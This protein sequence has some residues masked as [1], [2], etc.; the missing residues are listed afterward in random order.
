MK[1]EISIDRSTLLERL[2]LIKSLLLSYGGEPFAGYFLVTGWVWYFISMSHTKIGGVLLSAHA[3]DQINDLKKEQEVFYL[4]PYIDQEAISTF[5][6]VLENSDNDSV[7]FAIQGSSDSYFELSLTLDDVTVSERLIS[8]KGRITHTDF[9]RYFE[10]GRK[11]I[12]AKAGLDQK[13]HMDDNPDKNP[14]A[15][16]LLQNATEILKEWRFQHVSIHNK[17]DHLFIC[18]PLPVHSRGEIYYRFFLLIMKSII[19]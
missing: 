16:H 12:S 2:K 11:D 8:K 7:G 17:S 13:Y 19:K 9:N 1:L 18:D 14:I 6:P 10:I 15:V 3:P 4:E 5:I